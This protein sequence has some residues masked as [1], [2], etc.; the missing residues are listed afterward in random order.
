MEEPKSPRAGPVFP[1]FM[2]EMTAA[3]RSSRRLSREVSVIKFPPDFPHPLW[4]NLKKA[5]PLAGSSLANTRCLADSRVPSRAVGSHHQGRS[6]S[7]LR[8]VEGTVKGLFSC[9]EIKING[10]HLVFRSIILYYISLLHEN[11]CDH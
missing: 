4:S 8:Q 7:G 5:M 11:G 3:T 1:K 10:I 9:S 6:F 2:T